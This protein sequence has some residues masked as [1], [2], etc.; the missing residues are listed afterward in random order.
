MSM[1]STIQNYKLP[2][3]TQTLGLRHMTATDVPQV[4]ILLAEYLKKFSLAPVFNEEEIMHW[5]M[6]RKSILYAYVQDVSF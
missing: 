4:T 1:E 6:P 3:E 5:L 2:S